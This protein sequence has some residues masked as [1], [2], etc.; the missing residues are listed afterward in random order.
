MNFCYILDYFQANIFNY[1]VWFEYS[2]S[3]NQLLIYKPS[4]TIALHNCEDTI[5]K[6]Y[7][8]LN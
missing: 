8:N 7:F 2:L 4:I 1:F 3:N 6:H 5:D